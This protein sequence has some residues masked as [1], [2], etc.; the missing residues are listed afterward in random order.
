MLFVSSDPAAARL[1]SSKSSI[2]CPP[3]DELD[4][5]SSSDLSSP[6]S[7]T[8]LSSPVLVFRSSKS[9]I[10]CPPSDELD[11]FSS[12]DLSSPPSLQNELE[13]QKSVICRLRRELGMLLCVLGTMVTLTPGT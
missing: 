13:Q 8:Y 6:P 4:S 9:S 10:L 7:L 2:L 11:S 3:S 5:F 1:R 12:S